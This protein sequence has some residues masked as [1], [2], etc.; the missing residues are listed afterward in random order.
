MK[1]NRD[2]IEAIVKSLDTGTL[3]N[4]L[5]AKGIH[6]GQPAD[7]QESPLYSTDKEENS[8]GWNNIKIEL[9]KKEKPPI[10]SPEAYLKP[11]VVEQQMQPEYIA[12]ENPP[13]LEPWMTTGGAQG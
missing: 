7:G 4:M 10:H 12:S 9:D 6:I 13:M 5:A 2:A 1:P 11:K 8:Q 3:V